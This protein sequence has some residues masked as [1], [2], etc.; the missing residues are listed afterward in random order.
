M[1]SYLGTALVVPAVA[2]V[3]WQLKKQAA[4]PAE[5]LPNE[6]GYVLKG[7][8]LQSGIAWC[9]IVMAFMG[10]AAGLYFPLSLLGQGDSAGKAVFLGF[11]FILPASAFAV[12]AHYMIRDSRIRI[13]LTPTGVTRRIGKCAIHIPWDDV[14]KVTTSESGSLVLSNASGE[15]VIVKKTLVGASAGVEYIRVHLQ[16]RVNLGALV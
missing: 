5:K 14:R 7:S 9:A 4:G 6:E 8:F 11:L 12:L 3:L 10:F 2:L 13:E 1:S 16:P 15:Q